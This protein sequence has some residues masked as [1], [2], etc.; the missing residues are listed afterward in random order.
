[1]YPIQVN[2][3]YLQ[4]MYMYSTKKEDVIGT[5]PIRNCAKLPN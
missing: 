2:Y 1:M 3:M 5:V 4:C